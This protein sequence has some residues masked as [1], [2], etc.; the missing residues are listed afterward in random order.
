MTDGTDATRILNAAA[1]GDPAAAEQLL[2][3]VYAEL[4]AL[5]ASHFRNQRQDHTLQPT[6]L[7]HE[8]FLRLVDQTHVGW[9]SRAHFM[10]IAATAMRQILTDHARRKKAEKRGG[11]LRRVNL[12][13]AADAAEQQQ[14][15]LV[16]LDDILSR[17][18]ELDPRKHRVVELRYFGGLSVDEVAEVLGVSK[19]T[20]E[21]DWRAAR[22]WLNVELSRS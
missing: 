8:V 11:G 12:E 3:L 22:A 1:D 14:V 10:A 21:S 5:A 2:P 9:R 15:D 13:H 16:A 6:A 7:V 18:A 4:R 19:T 17:L 20:V